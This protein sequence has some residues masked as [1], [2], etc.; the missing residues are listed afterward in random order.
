[1][2]GKNYAILLSA[3]L[4]DIT[5]LFGLVN[6]VE[7]FIYGLIYGIV[8]RIRQ[9]TTPTMIVHPTGNRALLLALVIPQIWGITLQDANQLLLLLLLSLALPLVVIIGWKYILRLDKAKQVPKK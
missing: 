4:W 5:H 7:R 1:M 6:F 2:I 3:F 9:N 8:F